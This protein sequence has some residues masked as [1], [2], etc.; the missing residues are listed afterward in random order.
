MNLPTPYYADDAVT[1]YHVIDCHHEHI[2]GT[3]S[4]IQGTSPGRERTLAATGA[5]KGIQAR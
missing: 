5:T 3:A 4:Q 1:I 2:S